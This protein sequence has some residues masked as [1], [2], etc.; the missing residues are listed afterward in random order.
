[1][2]KAQP[3]DAGLSRVIKHWLKQS[4]LRY[5]VDTDRKQVATGLTAEQVKFSTSLPELWNASVAGIVEVY[6]STTS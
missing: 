4:Q 6:G 3:A 1:M 2:G 5:L